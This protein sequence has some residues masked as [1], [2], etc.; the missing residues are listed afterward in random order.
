MRVILDDSF[1]IGNEIIATFTG[2]RLVSKTR[3]DTPKDVD[4]LHKRAYQGVTNNSEVMEKFKN[5][6]K[7]T[8]TINFCKK[9]CYYE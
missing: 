5:R 2:K 3:I 9:L 6:N 1:R 8:S 7:L 4:V